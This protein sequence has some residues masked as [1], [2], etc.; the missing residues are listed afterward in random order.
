MKCRGAV[1]GLWSFKI[2]VHVSHALQLA[3]AAFGWGRWG[4]WLYK[5]RPS[6]DSFLVP[7]KLALNLNFM[8][9]L[10]PEPHLAGVGGCYQ[11]PV[12]LDG[13]NENRQ[14]WWVHP[15][16]ACVSSFLIWYL[17]NM[18]ASPIISCWFIESSVPEKSFFLGVRRKTVS[19]LWNLAHVE[20]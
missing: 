10:L 8:C 15:D 18:R 9:I 4:E 20:I 14:W 7:P 3:D 16:N 1:W 2:N 11:P 13:G 5:Y 12:C 19:L 6:W 17:I